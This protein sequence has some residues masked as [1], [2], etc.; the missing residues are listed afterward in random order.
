MPLGLIRTIW[1]LALSCPAMTEG[2]PAL[3][4]FRAM[5]L[6]EGWTNCVVSFGA[7]LKLCQLIAARGVVWLI[8]S[9][10]GAVGVIVAPPPTTCPPWGFAWTGF[11]N[12]NPARIRA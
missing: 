5:A 7:M 8:V 3:T 11:V 9:V 10:F 12:S 2:S 6:A 1:P 4:R